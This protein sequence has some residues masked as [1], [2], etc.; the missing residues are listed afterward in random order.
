MDASPLAFR[1]TGQKLA[2]A[3]I[4][5]CI[6]LLNYYRKSF[7]ALNLI[8]DSELSN[9][10]LARKRILTRLSVIFL[11]VGISS[12][13]AFLVGENLA[14]AVPGFLPITAALVGV[15]CLVAREIVRT[16]LAGRDFVRGELSLPR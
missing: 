16:Q 12:M 11:V 6:A 4:I 14:N 2:S 7:Y 3:G 5:V 9:S 15:A 10:I 8:A 1:P 13:L